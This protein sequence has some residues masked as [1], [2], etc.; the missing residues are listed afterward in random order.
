M[1]NINNTKVKTFLPQ[2]ATGR[3]YTENVVNTSSDSD[4]DSFTMNT[5][6]NLSYTPKLGKNHDI[7]AFLRFD[8]ED[9]RRTSQYLFSTNSASS[10]LTD[11]SID[12]RTNISGSASSSLGQTRSV[13]LL[14]NVQY[15]LLDRYIING[16]IRGDGNSRFGANNRYG[17]FPSISGRWRVSGEKFMQKTKKYI[18]DLSF[19]ASYGKSGNVPRNDYSYFN[20]YQNYGFSY[21]DNAGVYSTN[22]EL[23]DLRWETVTQSNVGIT[24]NMFKNNLS[25]DFDLY[26][27]RTTDLFYQ[28]LQIATYNGYGGVDMNGGTLDNQGWEFNINGT[29][30]K[31]KKLRWDLSFN[32]AHNENIIRSISPLVPRE[33]R[34]KVTSNNVYKVFIQENNPFGSFYGFKFKGVYSDR[35]ATIAKDEGGNQ[36]VGPNGDKIYMRFAYPSIDYVFQPGDAIYE[37]INHDGNIDYKDIVYL[38]NG[39]PKLTGGFGSQWIFKGNL[40]FNINF[41]YRLG[42]D[43]INGTKINTTN[44]YGFNNQ[45]T[46]VLRR[47][48]KEGDIT[49]MPRAVYGG[50]YNFLGS[51]RY[52]ED[53]SFLRVRSV[54][55]KYDFAKNLM[56]RIGMRSFSAN[57]TVE[58]ILTFT[59]YTGQ[60]PEVPVRLNGTNTVVD[61]STTP[62]IK[63][64]TLG[65][66]A[67]F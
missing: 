12:S 67:N 11:P 63:T 22:M 48:K 39:N 7:V 9:S 37:D 16:S 29:V 3:P 42:Y 47:W 13:G 25:M 62:P 43:V 40:K 19:R 45:S 17:L 10:F 38:G 18:D 44:M 1:V 54:V 28:G 35:D 14:A 27:K 46:A 65:L 57:L 66:T 56:K 41:S 2:I 58:N 49:D 21:L 32:I 23:T 4:G 6:I 64:V 59:R 34:G 31:N 5:N 8:S 20:I 51:D 52:I 50:G 36:I 26:R 24:L 60:D 53:G 33:N 30:L 55:L 15:K 61:N